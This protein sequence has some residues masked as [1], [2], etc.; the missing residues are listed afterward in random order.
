MEPIISLILPAY[1]VEKYIEACVHSCEKQ[2]LPRD[3]YEIIIVNDGSTPPLTLNVIN[4]LAGAYG[5]I[6]V[7]DQDNQGLSMA[8]NN[9]FEYAR[10]KYIWFIDSDDTITVNCLKTLVGIMDELGLDALAVA[11]KVPFLSEF[12]KGLRLVDNV[13]RIYDGPD[14]ILHSG[15]F[16][17]GAW[18]YIFRRNFWKS[19]KFQ[20][21]PNIY[22]EDTQLIGYT[23][24]KAKKVAA[25][26]SFSCYNYIQRD[27][28]IM[29]S[30]PTKPKLLSNAVIIKTHLE[31][32]ENAVNSDLS[33]WFLASA[34]GS[35]IDGIHK[36][37]QMGG[38]KTL[39]DDFLSSLRSRP[40]FIYGS[41][42]IHR[43]Y[44][45]LILHYPYFYIRLCRFLK[46]S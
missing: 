27:G 23:I 45:Y 2:D 19:N 35:F 26:T 25:L 21:Y 28:S 13:S 29:N 32:A 3:S 17:I 22:Y 9:G 7:I 4:S 42:T 44:Q 37:I 43:I 6:V 46:R 1:N 18:G 16:I 33:R 10:G 31:Y 41:R 39:L 11:P 24:S 5:N 8:R 40:A 30:S 15:R 14:F 12:P 34:S 38:D 20:F 36:I